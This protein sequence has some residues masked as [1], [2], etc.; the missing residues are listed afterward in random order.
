MDAILSNLPPSWQTPCRQRMKWRRDSSRNATSASKRLRRLRTGAIGLCERGCPPAQDEELLKDE[1]EERPPTRKRR[2]PG[3]RKH[4]DHDERE[5]QDEPRDR[6]EHRKPQLPGPTPATAAGNGQA[7][8][9]DE[10]G[11]PA[12]K[13]SPAWVSRPTASARSRWPHRL[14]P[15]SRGCAPACGSGPAGADPRARQRAHPE[16]VSTFLAAGQNHAQRPGTVPWIENEP[17]ERSTV[18][19]LGAPVP[20]PLVDEEAPDLGPADEAAPLRPWP[21]SRSSRLSRTSIRGKGWKIVTSSRNKPSRSRPR[22]LPSNPKRQ[23]SPPPMPRAPR[24]RRSKR[25][26]PRQR[27]RTTRTKPIATTDVRSRSEPPSGTLVGRRP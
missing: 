8:A 16:Q 7:Q 1:R 2:K 25:Q 21:D 19:R 22:R 13:A 5:L 14:V 3:A 10:P 24:R 27:N 9:E 18:P 4:H 23:T 17:E 20:T 15:V 26:C 12:A 6:P 11:K